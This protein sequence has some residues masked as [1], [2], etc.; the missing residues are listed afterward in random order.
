MS[1]KYRVKK[2]WGHGDAF[3]REVCAIQPTNRTA[4]SRKWDG[5]GKLPQEIDV[6]DGEVKTHMDA[7]IGLRRGGSCP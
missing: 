4:E 5:E 6:D 1:S 3:P 2:C 7:E